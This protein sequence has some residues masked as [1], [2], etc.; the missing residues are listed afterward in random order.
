MSYH[1]IKIN[2]LDLHIRKVLANYPTVFKTRLDVLHHIFIVL[3]SGYE[4]R[5]NE[6]YTMDDGELDKLPPIKHL[7]PDYL[8]AYPYPSPGIIREL[9][10][11][12]RP[13]IRQAALEILDIWRKALEYIHE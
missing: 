3:G 6:L 5:G 9:P 8:N 11:N 7:P 1:W 4:W 12:A 13:E 2:N 10:D